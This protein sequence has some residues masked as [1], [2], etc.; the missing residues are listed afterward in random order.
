[1]RLYHDARCSPHL[2]CATSESA[3]RFSSNHRIPTFDQGQPI[4]ATSATADAICS[5]KNDAKV[6]NSATAGK[7]AFNGV[8]RPWRSP[9]TAGKRQFN[10]SGGVKNEIRIARVR[11]DRRHRLG[12]A[13]IG[14]RTATAS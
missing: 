13:G 8:D 10:A 2:L 14:S 7:L 4:V 3:N 11:D 1:M 12:H 9:D 5:R 6:V